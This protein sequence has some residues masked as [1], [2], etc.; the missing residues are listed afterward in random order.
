MVDIM[1]IS[2][3]DKSLS[4][5]IEAV[6]KNPEMLKFVNDHLKT[7]KICKHE[8]KKLRYI[9]RYVPDRYET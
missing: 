9:L 6:M 3:M 7:E 2:I 1:D 8:V 4:I 5:S